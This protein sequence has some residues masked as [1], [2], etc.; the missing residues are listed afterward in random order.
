[1]CTAPENVGPGGSKYTVASR[2]GES[3]AGSPPGGGAYA[4]RV[5]SLSITARWGAPRTHARPSSSVTSEGLA[6]R[7]W[8]ASA[9]SFSLTRSAATAAL[10][11]IETAPRL[12]KVPLPRGAT[13]VSTASTRTASMEMPRRSATSCAIVVAWPWPCDGKLVMQLTVPS[14]PIGGVAAEALG[15]HIQEA[16]HDERAHGHPDA[17]VGAEW[18]L[19]GQDG[20]GLVL[21]RG[22]AVRAR[23]DRS[24]PEWL[25][26][27]GERVDVVRP[28]VGHRARSEATE[29]AVGLRGDLDL[30]PLRAGVRPRGEALAT[31]LDPLDRA[32]EHARGRG[33]RHVLR[34][35]VRLETEAASDV[36]RDDPH[37]GLGEVERGGERREHDGRRLGGGPHGERLAV[38]VDEDT[39]RLQG[40]RG[41]VPV[42]ERLAQHQRRARER[43]FHVA[44]AVVA[45]KEDVVG[46]EGGVDRHGRREWLVLDPDE[47]TRVG[48]DLRAR[49]HDRGDGLAA[50]ARAGIG[51]N[52][53]RR[54]R[55]P[56]PPESRGEKAGDPGQGGGP[57]PPED[58]RQAGRGA[59]VHPANR[60]VSV[61]G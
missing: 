16:L 5:T 29:H 39:A 44:P 1:M 13:S 15:D 55:E 9:W 48:G 18:R 6:S 7:Q 51:E 43:A 24:T 37:A 61:R 19:V 12:P 32:S 17:A 40:R 47:L 38:P 57:G 14:A 45:A 8:A 54:R 10:P 46:R 3:P 49:R 22:R 30:H 11:S 52:G 34:K 31:L 2:P 53:P 41:A 50:E 23:Q 33:D 25:E 56:L 42:L 60:R 28:A 4:R 36:G 21:V 59:R 26:G 20:D 58:R 27:A 35:D